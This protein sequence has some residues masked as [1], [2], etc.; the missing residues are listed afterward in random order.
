MVVYFILASILIVVSI[1]FGLDKWFAPD[2]KNNKCQ[3]AKSF[4]RISGCIL[5]ALFAFS[6]LFL[7]F[8]DLS[9]NLNNRIIALEGVGLFSLLFAVLGFI[10]SVFIY[11]NKMIEYSKSVNEN[12]ESADKISM[13]AKE[14][15]ES[16][17]LLKKPEQK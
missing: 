3:D 4:H 5:S 6:F 15:E 8:Y 11:H 16:D 9:K 7:G 1:L 14:L 2:Y 13:D 10:F 17:S 12:K